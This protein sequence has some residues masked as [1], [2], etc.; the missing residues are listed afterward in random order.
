[1]KASVLSRHGP[2]AR[3]PRR[4]LVDV[5]VALFALATAI[6]ALFHDGYHP[7]AVAI[8]ALFVVV[9][10][11][12]LRRIYPVPVYGW[13]I[14]T[15]ALAALWN[16]Y[17]IAGLAVLIALY[18][19]AATQTRQTA[20]AAAGVLGAVIVGGTVREAGSSWWYDSIFLFGLAAAALG[21]GLYV[22]TRRAYLAELHDRAERLERERDQQGALAAA[23]ER[24]R[25]AREM[26]DIVAHHLTVMVALS[27]G[28]IAATAASPERGIEVMRTVSATG[29]RALAD[30]RRLL[31]VLRHTDDEAPDALQPVPDLAELDVLIERVR[32]AG[33]A[34][35]VEVHGAV[36]DV[37]AGVQLTV[38]RIIQEALTNTLKH[39]G[40]EAHASVRL[41]YQ[42]GELLVDVDD[43]GAGASATAIGVGAGLSGMRERV[44]AYGGEVHS[45][46]RRAGGWR[47][48]ARLR[49]DE[50]E[51]EHRVDSP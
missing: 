23:A 35:T 33:L 31:G 20:L 48:S 44:H 6:P 15:A 27:E 36:P 30:T 1:M 10:P 43:D 42:P 14:A 4:W 46:P 5:L 47:V 34:T 18:T 40:A 9:T 22:A 32:A 45:G 16:N 50:A 49:L 39:G 2:A 7:P 19:V 38:Y 17:V 51:V 25:I 8:L 21:L 12:V 28:A 29:R 13:V 37:P 24:S 26:H 41:R 3:K 11:L